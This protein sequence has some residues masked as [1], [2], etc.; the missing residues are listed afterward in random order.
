M[1]CSIVVNAAGAFSANL[2]EKLGVGAGTKDAV[3]GVA[4][5]VEP[6]KRSAVC[7]R[8]VSSDRFGLILFRSVSR[9]CK[10][11]F[12]FLYYKM[13]F[14]LDPVEFGG[15]LK[16]GNITVRENCKGLNAKRRGKAVFVLSGSV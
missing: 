5:P 3:A 7:F 8:L 15:F 10:F 6:R 11:L 16:S 14:S 12:Y 13:P 1:E 9:C 4:V 2:V